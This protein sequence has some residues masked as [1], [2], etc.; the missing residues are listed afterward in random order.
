MTA[1]QYRADVL[2]RLERAET[3][4]P[5]PT[6]RNAT[7]RRLTAAILAERDRPPAADTRPFPFLTLD[8]RPCEP[9]GYAAAVDARPR[10][11]LGALQAKGGP[12]NGPFA[13][14]RLP[15]RNR[16]EPNLS[17]GQTRPHRA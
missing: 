11:N 2:T 12:T 15:L 1:R 9:L 10:T 8:H 16:L 5:D 3:P 4:P 6:D 13:F 14:C 17:L 7:L